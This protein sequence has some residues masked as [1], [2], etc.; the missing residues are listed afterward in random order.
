MRR[1]TDRRT[2]LRAL[3]F[4]RSQA[5]AEETWKCRRGKRAI[6]LIKRSFTL[7]WV[8][9][10]SLSTSKSLK[11]KNEAYRTRLGTVSAGLPGRV[12]P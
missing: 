9:A 5:A 6:V 3:Q 11:L 2:D 1:P 10:R 4:A 8:E 12:H 7:A